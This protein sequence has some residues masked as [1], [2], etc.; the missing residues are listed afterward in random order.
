[1]STKPTPQELLSAI[2][3]NCIMCSGGSRKEANNCTIKYC[4]LY[5]YRLGIHKPKETMKGQTNIFE[6][7]KHDETQMTEGEEQ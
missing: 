6:L 7:L 3:A 1:M 5:P 4:P 2:R